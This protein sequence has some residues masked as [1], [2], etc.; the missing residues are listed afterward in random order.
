MPHE[1]YLR[2][3]LVH[4]GS[5]GVHA[6]LQNAVDRLKATKRPPKWLVAQL[7]G[8]VPRAVASAHEIALWRNTAPD[9]PE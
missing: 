7:E 3:N 8:L 5:V 6:G 4:C 9:A 1:E 2:R